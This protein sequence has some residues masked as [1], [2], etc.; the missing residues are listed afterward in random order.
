MINAALRGKDMDSDECGC[1][2]GGVCCGGNA[3]KPS[4]SEEQEYPHL[5]VK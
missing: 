2:E 3:E 5:E 4:C 1:G